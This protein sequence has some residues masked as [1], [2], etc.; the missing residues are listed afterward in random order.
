M[1]SERLHR[2]E[3]CGVIIAEAPADTSGDVLCPECTDHLSDAATELLRRAAHRVRDLG[4]AA[5]SDGWTVG[6]YLVYEDDGGVTAACTFV[7]DAA[8]I[9]MM[10]PALAGHL[11][12]WLEWSASPPLEPLEQREALALA[13]A[14]LT[15]PP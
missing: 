14:L 13:R 5:E 8:W 11:A 1:T 9:A 10:S 6:G 12:A 7:E 3:L 2:C 15:T 4:E